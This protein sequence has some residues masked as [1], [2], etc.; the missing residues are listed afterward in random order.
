V[1]LVAR[2]M[3][4]S[5]NQAAALITSGQVSVKGLEAPKSS[6]EVS[7]STEI[8]VT[9]GLYVARSAGKLS[10]ALDAFEITVPQLCLDIGASTGGFTQV[11]LERGAAKVLA[12]D[13]GHN[14]LASE[15]RDDSRVVNLEGINVRELNASGLGAQPDQIGLTVADLS[16]ISLT[17]VADK[18]LELAPE[19][20]VVALIKP[21]FELQRSRLNKAGVVA[22]E[23]D[24]IEAVTKVVSAFEAAGYGLQQLAPSEV[25]GSHGNQEYLAHFSPASLGRISLD[26]IQDLI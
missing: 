3:A 2:G 8:R 21:Q 12:V 10:A 13:V 26:E 6:S 16:F 18:F 24:R 5:R 9:G 1:A 14:Q 25:V 23:A 19:A 11:L 17:M 20:E 4:R 7:E 15:L 22:Q